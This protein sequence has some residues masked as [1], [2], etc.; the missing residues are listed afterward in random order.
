MI[1]K[2]GV[3][4]TKRGIARYLRAGANYLTKPEVAL[5][6]NGYAGPNGSV[7]AIGACN[8]ASDEQF[9][10]SDSYALKALADFNDRPSTTKFMV[11]DRMRKLARE[12]EHGGSL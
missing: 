12:L 1:S 10:V 3:V 6:K 7:C 8:E 2:R 9:Y 11:I 4:L 5:Y